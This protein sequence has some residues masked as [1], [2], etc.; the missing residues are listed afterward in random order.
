MD[1]QQYCAWLWR[2]RQTHSRTTSKPVK[3]SSSHVGVWD[4]DAQCMGMGA[5]PSDRVGSQT[6]CRGSIYFC[7]GVHWHESE[8]DQSYRIL[9]CQFTSEFPPSPVTGT[10]GERVK[11]EWKLTSIGIW[12]LRGTEILSAFGCGPED[13][14]TLSG[15][16]ILPIDPRHHLTSSVN[17][18][19]GSPKVLR[20]RKIT[21][22]NSGF[23]HS[24]VL[25][26]EQGEFNQ[27]RGN[28]FRGFHT[29]GGAVKGTRR[30]ELVRQSWHIDITRLR[31][32]KGDFSSILP[33]VNSNSS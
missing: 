13:Q 15:V 9:C 4:M 3:Q 1:E 31:C 21:T 33:P 27:L 32:G 20:C 28:L 2:A 18:L 11:S 16:H 12:T 19:S 22:R 23:C 30:T 6:R 17:E 5:G 25:M 24:I 10:V 14:K 7:L 29:A 26:R 8:S